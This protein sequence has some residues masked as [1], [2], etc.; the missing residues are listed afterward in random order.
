MGYENKYDLMDKAV[1][2]RDSIYLAKE[3]PNSVI[4]T[5]IPRVSRTDEEII[6]AVS[7]DMAGTLGAKLEP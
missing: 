7:E 4:S 5:P 6:R 1:F 3:N 2:P